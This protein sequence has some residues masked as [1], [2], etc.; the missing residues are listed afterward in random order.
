M[1]TLDDKIDKVREFVKS[2]CDK[3]EWKDNVRLVDKDLTDWKY[4]VQLVVK[5]SKILA[6]KLGSDEEIAELGALLHDIA[7]IDSLKNDPTHEII[8][9]PM[10]ERL[11]GKLGYPEKTIEEVKHCVETHKS[12]DSNPPKTV[13]AKIVANADAMAHFDSIP[14]L[15]RIGLKNNDND[16]EAA[17]GWV[18]QKIENNWRNKLTLPEAKEMMKEKYDAIR[19]VLGSM[20]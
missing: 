9:V 19:I 18:R 13:S 11:L 10:A 17:V 8:G 7:W 1:I 5:Y 6:R 14:Y 16:L 4:H 12:M 2:K 3:T 15:I 20:E